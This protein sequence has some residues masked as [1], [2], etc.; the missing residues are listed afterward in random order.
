MSVDISVDGR[1]IPACIVSSMSPGDLTTLT[2]L[3]QFCVL[4]AD[5]NTEAVIFQSILPRA[6]YL[7]SG[8][9][10]NCAAHTKKSHV[11]KGQEKALGSSRKSIKLGEQG[12][13]VHANDLGQISEKRYFPVCRLVLIY[14]PSFQ[15]LSMLEMN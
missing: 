3:F 10:Q 12:D 9:L 5:A 8:L 14:L 15:V 6:L 1:V 11:E 13:K 2:K 7:H 4:G